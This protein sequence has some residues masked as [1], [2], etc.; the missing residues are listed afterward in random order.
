MRPRHP[1]NLRA[2]AAAALFVA[3]A[4]ASCHSPDWG[5]PSSSLR[6]HP[7]STTRFPASAP[8]ARGAG[9][10]DASEDEAPPEKAA[11]PAK[12]AR[13]MDQPRLFLSRDVLDAL[14]T[15]AS[16]N[17]P[18]WAA[19]RSRCQGL[20]NAKVEYP[21]GLPY[22]GAGN[23]G[24]GYQGQGYF[25]PLMELSLCHQIAKSV[26]GANASAYAR[27]AVEVL[28][29]MSEPEGSHAPRPERDSVYGVRFYGVGMAVAYDWLYPE[30]TDG[31]RRRVAAAL[32]RWIAAYEKSGFGRDHPQGNYFA[33]YYSAKALAALALEGRGTQPR[34]TTSWSDFLNRV[35]VKQVAPFYATRM[36]GGGWPEGWG[37]G[38]LA[39]LNMSLPSWAARTAKGVDLIGGTEPRFRFPLDQAH[40]LMHFSWPSRKT[41]DDR[42]THH[43]SDAPSAFDPLLAYATWGFVSMAR[44]PIAPTF[45]RFAREVREASGARD[46]EPWVA[47]LFWN[48]QAPE[49][50]FDRLPR[51]Y[52]AR[53]MQAAAMRSTWEKDA[54]W[55]SFS[56]GP[57][58]NNPDSGEM[59]FD[60]GSL[61]VV[62]GDR[63][64]LV[65]A[66][67]A[68]I[69]SSKGTQD[70]AKLEQKVYDSL[71]GDKAER[72]LFNVFYAKTQK[73]PRYG[74]IANPTAKTALGRF[75]DRG[76]FVT[77]RGDRLEEVYRAGTVASWSRQIVYLR[78]SLF[79]IEDRTEALDPR[80]DQWLAFH[81]AR[82]LVQRDGGRWDAES[83]GALDGA[84]TPLLPRG[85]TLKVVDLFAAGK[86]WRAEIRPASQRPKQ[87]WVTV[88]DAAASREDAARSELLTIAEGDAEG[89]ALKTRDRAYVIVFAPEGGN[90]K[91]DGSVAYA[92]PAS[93]GPALH[94]IADAA[95]NASYGV[96]VQNHRVHVSP[97]G[98]GRPVKAS[99]E[100]TLAF[101][102]QPNGSVTPLP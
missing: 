87:R 86:V 31:D 47:M 74:Q 4:T 13:G 93:S 90:G 85:S 43:A 51:S 94:V 53:G 73:T 54:V 59:L 37:Y 102:V 63:P 45:H 57:Y 92:A 56:A 44:D 28:R 30:L 12:V 38:T 2:L 62:R 97:G 9:E 32:D 46:V 33:G 82:P 68:L 23:I 77:A 67:T 40:Y 42:G 21:D 100:G 15:R 78:P 22:P 18:E 35:H 80:A 99:R 39:S 84:L 5:G 70:G 11:Q 52:V 3:S 20:R 72:A 95:P 55:A 29:K 69:K 26:D 36:G 76:A 34:S 27:K 96:T 101:T 48:E 24:E 1:V 19:L 64:L 83:N 6:P 71:F 25:T 41:I 50:G 8:E 16:A 14:V 91:L 98:G 66:P 10:G 49:A 60:Q 61:S 79:V 81:T 75:E 17:S 89:I 7:P 65:Y 88:F 58:V